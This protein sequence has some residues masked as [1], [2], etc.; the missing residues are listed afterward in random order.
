ME[1]LHDIVGTDGETILWWQ[2]A[3]RAAIIFF[4]LVLLARLGGTRAFGS[5]SALD[6][7][8]AFLLGSTLSRALTGNSPLLPTLFAGAVLVI[9]HASLAR[10]AVW[11]EPVGFCVKGRAVKL[12]EDGRL[13]RPSMRKA[14]VTERDLREHLRYELHTDHLEEV[15]DAYLERGGNVS[16]VKRQGGQGA[17]AA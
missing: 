16:F 1:W 5:W 13:L 7:V 10:L 4:Y 15:D 6:I 3:I 14:G 17:G 9:L 8:L 2:M 11:W 12:M